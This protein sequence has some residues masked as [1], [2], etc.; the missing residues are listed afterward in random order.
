MKAQLPGSMSR[1]GSVMLSTDETFVGSSPHCVK[2]HNFTFSVA[3]N[4][5]ETVRL[6]KIHTAGN[7][8]KLRYFTPCLNERKL[9]LWKKL[10]YF[11]SFIS[12]MS[13][14]DQE[15]VSVLRRCPTKSFYQIEV[16]HI[17]RF[18]YSLVSELISN[19]KV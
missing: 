18:H 10:Y 7:L 8:V 14:W 19:T 9:V 13:N 3:R 12:E 17:K 6:H 15:T 4:F 11:L 5:T 1:Y 16:F 2:C